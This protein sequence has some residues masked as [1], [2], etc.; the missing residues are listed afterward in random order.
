MSG[1]AVRRAGQGLRA[2]FAWTGA[3]SVVNLLAA[4]LTALLV[5][6]IIGPAAFG[7]AALAWLFV[8]LAEVIVATLFVDPLIQ[9]RHLDMAVVDAAFT[10]ML[11]T[12]VAL[13]LLILAAAPLL[14]WLYGR[15]ALT[16][17][18]AVQ[19]STCVLRAL[20]GAPE[21]LLARKLRFRA[22]AIRNIAARIAGTAVALAAAWLGTGAWSVILGNVAFAAIATLTI[23]PMIRRK[24]RLLLHPGHVRGLWS[25]GA[26]SM[27]DALLWTATSRVFSFSVGYFQGIRV[28]GELN[29]AFRINDTLCNLILAVTTRLALP[30][31]S[32]LAEDRRRLEQAYL[33]GTRLVTLLVAPA[34]LGLAFIS[35]ELIALALG[36]DWKLAAPALVAVCLFSLFDF[37]CVLAHS[38][39]KAVGRPALLIA[40]NLIGLTYVAA[41]TVAVRRL[42]FTA[43]LAVWVSWGAVFLLCSLR[44]IRTALGTAFPAQL[45]AF[46]PAL[47]PSLGMCAAL[48]AVTLLHPA[49]SPATLLLKLA[50]GG[51]SYGLLVLVFE[52]P[53]V[54][55]VL[56]RPVAAGG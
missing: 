4:L 24:P 40:P 18:L 47:L 20:R 7:L 3:E 50:A 34:F 31:F 12:G 27:L 35:R 19:G 53:L 33:D 55:Q 9:R 46:A 8:S 38:V 17:L 14:A 51:A 5:G 37:V 16:A 49:A 36:P 41:G 44:N 13:Y 56:G 43:E 23:L 10:A 26:F 42:G 2:S 22:L 30:I 1:P 29:F 52:R 11:A 54:M 32:R 25:F 45:R 6:R 39:V 48:A 28:L 15:P 21:A